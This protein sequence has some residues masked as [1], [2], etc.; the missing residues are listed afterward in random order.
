MYCFCRAK[1]FIG[2]LFSEKPSEVFFFLF[3]ESLI[4]VDFADYHGQIIDIDLIPIISRFF[5][6]RGLWFILAPFFFKVFLADISCIVPEGFVDIINASISSLV[7]LYISK[8]VRV[9]ACP[10]SFGLFSVP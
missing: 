3:F 2:S 4:L 7:F 1:A 5:L 6:V 9:P 8:W 10:W